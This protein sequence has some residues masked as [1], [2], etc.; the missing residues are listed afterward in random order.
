MDQSRVKDRI[1]DA[2]AT[3]QHAL[4]QMDRV[5]GKLLIVFDKGKFRSILSIGDLQRAI[6]RGA[7]LEQQVSDALRPKVRVA[8]DTDSK[9]SVIEQMMQFRMEFMPVLNADGDLIEVMFWNEIMEGI[10]RKG[11]GVIQCPVVIMAGGKGTRLKPITNIIP[12]PLIP[13][14]EKPVIEWIIDS[15]FDFGVEKFLLSVNYKKEMIQGYFNQ[16]ERKYSIEYFEETQPLG[17]AGSLHLLDGKL[18][19]TFFVTNC[20]ILV[21]DDYSEILRY[22]KENRNELTAVAAVKSYTIPY[23][24]FRTENGVISEIQE[25]P[26]V[27]YFINAGMYILEPHLIREIPKNT[28]FHI[29]ELIEKL[30]AAKRRVG[31]FPVSPGSWLDIGEWEEYSKASK[32]L[33]FGDFK[34]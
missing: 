6:I 23:G 24:T 17:T 20:D 29:T 33:G 14:G 25:K 2:G 16:T 27:N 31:M 32:K 28:F 13:I 7:K 30:V 18:N 15:F 10:P 5:D 9:E 1:I 21:Q 34:I 22:H 4:Q 3:F 19:E 12:K 26:Q 11:L 8:L